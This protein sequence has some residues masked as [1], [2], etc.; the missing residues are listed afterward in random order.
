MKNLAPL[1]SLV[2]TIIILRLL[3][4]ALNKF[5]NRPGAH[6]R[7]IA[8]AKLPS[9]LRFLE[10][11]LFISF[12][13][14]IIIFTLFHIVKIHSGPVSGFEL[15]EALLIFVTAVPIAGLLCNFI[16]WLIPP[17]RKISEDNAKGIHGASFA[18]AN[19]GLAKFILIM[20]VVWAVFLG[21]YFLV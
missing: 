20:A 3:R 6:E 4:P 10:F 2:L 18:E 1:I 21:V 16:L 5:L 7:R 12:W 9:W 14:G 17:V 15:I 11:I 8:K 19:K 13:V